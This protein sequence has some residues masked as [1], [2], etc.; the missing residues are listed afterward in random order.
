MSAS[1]WWRILTIREADGVSTAVYNN[2]ISC[3]WWR[4]VVGRLGGQGAEVACLRDLLPCP[5]IPDH[6]PLPFLTARGVSRTLWLACRRFRPFRVV[7]MPI[8]V[9][10]PGCKKRYTVSEKFAGQQGPCP[11]CKTILTIPAKEDEVVIHAPEGAG[12]KDSKGQA[13]IRPILREET[14]FSLQWTLSIVG[15]IIGAFVVALLA[16]TI[17]RTMPELVGASA[18]FSWRLPWCGPAI[19]SCE[20]ASWS[21]IGGT[22][23]CFAWPAVRP[24]MRLSGEP[25]LTSNG[26]CSTDPEIWQVLVLAVGA[27]LAGS[28]AAFAA[29]D[30]D[31]LVG[32]VHY[33]LYLVVTVLLGW[34]AGLKF[35]LQ[36]G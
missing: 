35:F 13:V 9:T 18:R 7:S 16:R 3:P 22:N 29:F 15:A 26:S 8:H 34:I 17:A 19:V 23:C 1:K 25:T 12:P 11:H 14:R 32:M 20:T 31:Y 10:C 4:S 5:L 36:S 2:E 24:P 27:A 28:F 30:L 33:G 6:G 21:R